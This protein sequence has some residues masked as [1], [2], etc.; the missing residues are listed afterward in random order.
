MPLVC[1]G[2]VALAEPVAPGA[3]AGSYNASL[4]TASGGSGPW[5]MAAGAQPAS[6]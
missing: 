2:L 3:V 6:S 1:E 5:P 4:A